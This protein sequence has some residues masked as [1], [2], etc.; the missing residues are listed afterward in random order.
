MKSIGYIVICLFIFFIVI[1]RARAEYIL[2]YPG[3]MPGNPLYMVM[4][5]IDRIQFYWHWGNIAKARYHMEMSDKYLVEAK[6]LFEYKQYVLAV[7]ALK[8][9]NNYWMKISPH[10]DQAEKQRKDIQYLRVR[11]TEQGIAHQRIL[12][13]VRQELPDSFTW[14][15]EKGEPLHLDFRSL[16]EEAKKLRI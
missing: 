10:L 12:D 4:Q 15:P 1:S 3:P 9:S 16:F 14:R 13:R 5:I 6:M 2:P 8:Q 7:N 11:H